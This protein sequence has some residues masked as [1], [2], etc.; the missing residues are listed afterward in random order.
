V[1]APVRTRR[2]LNDVREGVLNESFVA[3]ELVGSK[4]GEC[5][6]EDPLHVGQSER[7]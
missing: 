5:L 7:M 4:G 2:A 6:A 3:D 1:Y